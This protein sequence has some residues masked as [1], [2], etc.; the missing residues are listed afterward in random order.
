MAMRHMIYQVNV[1]WRPN[2]ATYW[3]PY[4]EQY[5]LFHLVSSE[6]FL[7]DCCSANV[8]LPL[9]SLQSGTGAIDLLGVLSSCHHWSPWHLS[10]H[11]YLERVV[12][13]F[14]LNF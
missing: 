11:S 1:R 13:L 8:V 2:F 12:A 6:H 3:L 7:C 9:Q 4:L 10:W 14:T 5:L